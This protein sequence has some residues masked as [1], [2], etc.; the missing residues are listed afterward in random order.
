MSARFWIT[1]TAAVAA[2]ATACSSSGS[3]G[4]SGPGGASGSGRAAA[5]SNSVTISVK[6]DRLTAPDGMTLYYN[7]V[8]TAMNITCVGQCAS[9]WPPVLGDPKAGSGLDQ[10]DL[11]TA[12]R[13]D[14]GTQVTFYG[15]PLYMFSQDGPGNARGNGVQDAGGHWV[16]ATPQQASGG[17]TSS[18][19][20]TS[21]PSSNG[22]Y[23]GGY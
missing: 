17:G 2:F 15:H 4:G 10:Q 5:G 8:D 18:S 12:T 16:I 22:G 6:N 19:A 1:T 13:P 7:T 3:G 11:A 21:A 14:G 23:S 9:I 20:T